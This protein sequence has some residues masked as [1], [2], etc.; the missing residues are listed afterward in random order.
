M[1]T[2]G[3]Q[4]GITVDAKRAIAKLERLKAGF[5]VRT[6][7]SAIGLAQIYWIGRNLNAAGKVEG[8]QPWQVMAPITIA[9]RPQ[10]PSSHHFS[11]PYQ[12]LLQQSMVQEVNEGAA[13]VNVGTNAK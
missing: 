11:S 10:R 7:L 2:H 12:T 4:V 3:Q 13:S 1:P 6:I 9:R 8:G 5:A